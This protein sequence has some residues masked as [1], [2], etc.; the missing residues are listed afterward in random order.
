MS[1]MELRGVLFEK[2]LSH[3]FYRE[4]CQEN[5]PT[6]WWGRKEIVAYPQTIPQ[7]LNVLEVET[8]N[9]MNQHALQTWKSDRVFNDLEMTGE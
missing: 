4:C 6:H 7:K 9:E 8:D 5:V 2:A 1:S 3:G